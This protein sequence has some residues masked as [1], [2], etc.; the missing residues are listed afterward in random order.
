MTRREAMSRKSPIT[1]ITALCML[2]AACGLDDDGAAPFL[3]EDVAFPAF[4]D[5][6]IDGDPVEARLSDYF[7]ENRAGTR[8]VMINSAAGWCAPCMREAA[9]LPEF[10]AAYEPRGV[11]ILV[12]IFQDQ[13]GDPAGPEFAR[14]WIETFDL[15]VPVLIDTE[16]QTSRYFDVNAMP[17]SLVA[18]A[19]TLEILAVAVGAETGS[20]PMREYREL[21]DYFLD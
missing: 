19:E 13:R 15:E 12:A 6:D 14:S 16:F 2:A 4:L 5:G 9:A 1:V 20:D 21:L 3:L 18:D 17:A 11:A 10:A 8:L 7:A